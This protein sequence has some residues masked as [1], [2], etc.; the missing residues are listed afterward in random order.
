MAKKKTNNGMRRVSTLFVDILMLG[1]DMIEIILKIVG[2]I[3]RTYVR[4]VARII[5]WIKPD[6]VDLKHFDERI[7]DMVDDDA[8]DVHKLEDLRDDV[9]ALLTKKGIK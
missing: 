1:E 7:N 3:R 6:R 5:T 9:K 8:N 4:G 2:G